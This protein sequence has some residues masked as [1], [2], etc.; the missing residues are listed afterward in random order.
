MKKIANQIE[1]TPGSGTLRLLDWLET[2]QAQQAEPPAPDPD[3]PAFEVPDQPPVRLKDT[4]LDGAPDTEQADLHEECRIKI[5]ALKA[6]AWSGG[7]AAP[8]LVG[9]VDRYATIIARDPDGI[10]ARTIWSPANTME[11]VLQTHEIA[12]DEGRFNDELPAAVAAALEDMIQT[13]RVWF[14]GH[15]G[16]R[17]VYQHAQGHAEE[18]HSSNQ[19]AVVDAVVQAAEE[20][21]QVD[22]EATLPARENLDTAVGDT[23]AARS[24]WGEAS[25][26][27]WNLTAS[28]CR[29]VWRIA[30]KG[31]GVAAVDAIAGG[32]LFEF[33]VGNAAALGVFANAYM[34]VGGV[35][36]DHFIALVERT[37]KQRAAKKDRSGSDE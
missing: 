13:H 8:R 22:P 17:Q 32:Y 15:P 36:W 25:D 37:L 1:R 23:P 33:V 3:K 18:P 16:A 6:I 24:A 26:W 35:W 11:S 5:A 27:A 31:S 30:T 14:L 21:P 12:V 34:T 2:Q 28:I 10:G 29:K 20:S 7:N 9:A 19:R 4:G